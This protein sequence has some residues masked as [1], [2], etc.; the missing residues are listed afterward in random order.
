M[1]FI[2]QDLCIKVPVLKLPPG[3]VA[4]CNAKG[5]Q[6]EN[7]DDDAKTTNMWDDEVKLFGKPF[8]KIC[9][10]TIAG[11]YSFLGGWGR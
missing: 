7:S 3:G 1:S 6:K 2:C 11:F 9:I 8:L 10:L 5:S 4:A